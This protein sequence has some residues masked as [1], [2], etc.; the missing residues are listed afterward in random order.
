MGTSDTIIPSHISQNPIL[1]LIWWVSKSS[2]WS[3]KSL[4]KSFV[5]EV[6]SQD[7][8]AQVPTA[9]ISLQLLTSGSVCS[10][11]TLVHY[12][13]S[14]GSVSQG[15]RHL[16][17]PDRSSSNDHS[18]SVELGPCKICY[19]IHNG[20]R[21]KAPVLQSCRG[22]AYTKNGTGKRINLL[23][24]P[25]RNSPSPGQV[26]WAVMR[27]TNCTD[28]LGELVLVLSFSA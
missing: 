7:W 1:H 10:G 16:Q 9:W 22:Y 24:L 17:G 25:E 13:N 26:T 6:Y 8:G 2:S 18:S 21:R 28:L 19:F 11:N 5:M 20:T 14:Y 12:H 4:R 15:N 23:F 3:E 27:Y